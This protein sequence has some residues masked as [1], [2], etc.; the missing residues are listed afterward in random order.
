M[1]IVISD[2]LALTLESATDADYPVICW[3]NL[4]H[5]LEEIHII[6]RDVKLAEIGHRRSSKNTHMLK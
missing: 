3:N 1:P 4:I 6:S 5:T 2:A